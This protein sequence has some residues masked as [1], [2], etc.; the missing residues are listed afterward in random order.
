V[1]CRKRKPNIYR[2]LRERISGI[3]YGQKYRNWRT[4]RVSPIHCNPNEE[5]LDAFRSKTWLSRLTNKKLDLH[6][7]NETTFYFTG[8]ASRRTPETLVLIDIDCHASGSLAGAIAF[9]KYLREHYYRNLYWEVSTNGNGV[10]A[11]LVLRKYDVGGLMINDLL[12]H[13]LQP[14]LRRALAEQNFDVETVEVKGTCPDFEWG[15]K[16]GELLAYRSGTLAKLPR[17]AHRFDELAKTTVLS[18]DDLLRLGVPEIQPSEPVRL[19]MVGIESKGSI[20]GKHFQ[21]D[22]LDRL[23]NHYLHLANALLHRHSLGTK[24][25]SVAT[26]EDLSIFLMML[27]FFTKNMNGDGSLPMA[28][29]KAMWEA[30][31]EAGDIRRSWDGKRFATM[32]NYLS[33]LGLI[34]WQEERH[35]PDPI[36]HRGQAAK[37]M[38][39]EM[40]MGW[41][42]EP[43]R[44]QE[45]EK[46]AEERNLTKQ[47][48]KGEEKEASFR[49]TGL[50]EAS[51]DFVP[52]LPEAVIRPVKSWK[53][54]NTCPNP[55]EEIARIVGYMAA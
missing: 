47:Q 35:Y 19:R 1:R 52:S 34:Q 3:D 23:D 40:L 37:W 16:K 18:I 9:A 2:W 29:F 45:E 43:I 36:K 4:G 8:H 30:L 49:G 46:A 53:V 22:E 11:Y 20:A 39:S 25:R 26:A 48:E 33:D 6:F 55:D 17:E 31:F 54:P 42:E 10:H 38:A 12:L 15:Q 50:L 21:Q 27:R 24:G 44:T 41:L 14:F 13:R 32:R 51:D 28:R 7:K 5:V